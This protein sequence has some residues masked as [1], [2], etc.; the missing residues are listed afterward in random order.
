MTLTE[1]KAG[2]LDQAMA[3]SKERQ[4]LV[5]RLNQ[6]DQALLK[7]SGAIDLLDELTIEA[8]KQALFAVDGRNGE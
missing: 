6:V 5:A 1:R 4:D 8:P 7:V 2:L 3:L